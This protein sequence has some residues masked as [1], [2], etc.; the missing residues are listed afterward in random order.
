MCQT[1]RS[2][3]GT[4]PSAEAFLAR[5]AAVERQSYGPDHVEVASAVL[6]VSKI[7]TLILEDVLKQLVLSFLAE[8]RNLPDYCDYHYH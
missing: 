4:L 1:C 8:F 2:E 7:E 5:A 3:A 6:P